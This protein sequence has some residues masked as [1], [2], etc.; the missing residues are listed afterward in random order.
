MLHPCSTYRCQSRPQCSLAQPYPPTQGTNPEELFACGYASCYNGALQ[1]VAGK[2]EIKCGP[3]ETTA[4]V[5]FGPTA[6]GVGIAVKLDVR[7]ADVDAATAKK[8][9]ELAHDFC[10][11]SKATRGNIVVDINA[12]PM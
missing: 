2:N 9:G 11:Y 6:T 4:S 8:L 3:S 5:S 12:V 7:I 10:P 1:F